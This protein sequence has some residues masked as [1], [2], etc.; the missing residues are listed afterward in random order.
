MINGNSSNFEDI[1]IDK[2]TFLKN[3]IKKFNAIKNFFDKMTVF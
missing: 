3:Y 1:D 2:V